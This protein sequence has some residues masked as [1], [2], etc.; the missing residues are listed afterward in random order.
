MQNNK[1]HVK[2]FTGFLRLWFTRYRIKLVNH[3]GID[4]AGNDYKLKPKNLSVKIFVEMKANNFLQDN[5][6]Y[7]KYFE[8]KKK[9]K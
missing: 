2:G 9:F 1:E 6:R 5:E 4:D 3:C 7:L 8:K